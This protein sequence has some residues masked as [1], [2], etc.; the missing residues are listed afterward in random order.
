MDRL[1]VEQAEAEKLSLNPFKR[2]KQ[3]ADTLNDPSIVGEDIEIVV[4]PSSR[5]VSSGE[6]NTF[7]IYTLSPF[8]GRSALISAAETLEIARTTGILEELHQGAIE[9]GEI[10]G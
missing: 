8:L 7:L 6:K 9:Q 4:N 2:H 10:D 1:T 5:F 3:V